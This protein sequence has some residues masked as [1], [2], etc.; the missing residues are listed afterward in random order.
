MFLRV[1]PTNVVRF[2]RG[3][4]P[5]EYIP[6]PDRHPTARVDEHINYRYWIR[7]CIRLPLGAASGERMTNS[8]YYD[9]GIDS[10]TMALVQLR[11]Q[12]MSITNSFTEAFNEYLLL[13]KFWIV[14]D[15]LSLSR[16]S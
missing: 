13:Q 7:L 15:Y 3:H 8:R 5:S 10:V 1:W 9:A 14:T 4:F 6:K 2:F 16:S 11:K 12:A